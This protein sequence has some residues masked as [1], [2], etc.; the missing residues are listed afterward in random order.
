MYSIWLKSTAKWPGQ[1]GK[2]PLLVPVIEKKLNK[3]SYT[4]SMYILESV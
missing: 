4:C 2:L 1:Q 3:N